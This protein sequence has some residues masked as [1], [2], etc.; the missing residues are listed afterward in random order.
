MYF[1]RLLMIALIVLSTTLSGAM[2]AR[3]LG[4]TDVSVET[5]AVMSADHK[6]CCTDGTEQ[7]QGCHVLP[8]ILPAM[9]MDS[10]A[11]KLLRSVTFGPSILPT[12]FEPAGTLD[13]PRLV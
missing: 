6:T 3:H 8:A 4:P 11:Q 1:V 10:G 5:A 2:A 13:P 7:S 12:G 9:K